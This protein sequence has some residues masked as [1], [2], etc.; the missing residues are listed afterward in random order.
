MPE[1]NEFIPEAKKLLERATDTP[2]K[3]RFFYQ[4]PSGGW[5]MVTWRGFLDRS[6]ALAH[7]L[8][9]EGIVPGKK[10]AIFSK[11]RVEWPF[12]TMAIHA[13]R[14]V[15]VPIYQS[16]T[17]IETKYIINHSDAEVLFTE[18]DLLP[19]VL[20]IWKDIPAVRKVV[21]MGMGIDG[22]NSIDEILRRFN[23]AGAG[24]LS[25][26][27]VKNRV[28]SI[29]DACEFGTS[30]GDSALSSFEAMAEKIVPEDVSTILYTSGTTGVPKGVVLT[31]YNLYTNAEDWIN[32]LSPLIP[33]E[34]VDLLWLPISHIFGWGEMGLGN[35]LGF[36]TYMTT[37][38]DV[39]RHMPEVRPTIFISVPAYWEKL[40]C[41]AKEFSGNRAAQLERLHVLTGGRLKFC[42]S[43]GAGLKREVKEFFY[44]AGLLLIEGYGLTEC[45]PTLTM[46]RGEDFDFDT[47]GKPFPKVDIKLAPDGE[48]LARGPNIFKEYYKDAEA[49]R[50]TFTGD[51]WFKT[52]DIGTLTD[53]GFLKIVGRKKEII[54]TSGG[55]NISPQP[56]E[57][58]FRE[59]PYIEHIVL[60]GDERKYLVALVTLKEEALKT[61]AEGDGLKGLPL[62][63]LVRHPNVT[64]LVGK[65]IAR[66]NATLASF[67]TI[68][69][70]H[71]Y[72]GHLTVDGGFLT[73]S[74]KLRRKA[75]YE[76]FG[77]V[78]DGLYE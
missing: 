56:I 40:Y 26:S 17:A 62:T 12:C 38:I 68:K 58:L 25:T 22:T 20:S 69:K 59:D 54:V 48:I 63:D 7:Y 61:W 72:A 13:A 73:P 49:T 3:P 34:R 76:K 53:S 43:G 16:N 71:V 60:Y 30:T 19:L 74:L 24:P 64:D 45:S 65:T 55:K 70:F 10:V 28:I 77:S 33:D 35:T 52:G 11:N 9:A 5:E 42:L 1:K 51:G 6:L 2:D 75:V 50:E 57:Y 66:V 67:E 47:V 21:V 37:P 29:E 31:L 44:E 18:S 14:G 41:G 32:V 4:S 27:D 46:N 36:T 23:S 15:F 78:L 8:T 39:L